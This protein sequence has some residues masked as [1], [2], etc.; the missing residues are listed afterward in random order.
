MKNMNEFVKAEEEIRNTLAQENAK[1]SEHR[2][3][4]ELH[5]RNGHFWVCEQEVQGCIDTIRCNYHYQ[6]IYNS[7]LTL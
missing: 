6:M 2:K 5:S 4:W 1:H 3:Q 7:I